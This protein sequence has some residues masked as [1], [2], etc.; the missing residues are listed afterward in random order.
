MQAQLAKKLLEVGGLLLDQEK[1]EVLI[2]PRAREEG[3]WFGGGNIAQAADGTFWLV[4]RYRNGGDS[5]VGIE[6]GPRGAELSLWKSEDGG[7]S[8]EEAFS[9]LKD[10]LAPEG[11]EVLSIEGASLCADESGV[12]L[13]VS[14]EK[15]RDY[16]A[17]VKEFQK[18]GTG[19]WSIDV[20]QAS[21]VE[22]L[23]DAEVKCVLRSEP[24]SWLHLKD[25]VVFDRDGVRTMLVCSHPYSWASTNTG[26]AL[27]DDETGEW[28]IK[29]WSIESRGPSWDVAV[30]R[31][32]ER[33][34]L[35]ESGSIDEKRCLYFYD[36]AEC[37][38]DHGG[39]RPKGYSCE[40]IGGLAAGPDGKFPDLTRLSVE[41]PA[42][43]SP[44]G[45]GCSRYC[46]VCDTGEQY[47]VTWQQSQPDFSQPL[48]VNRVEKA[49]VVGILEG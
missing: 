25:P 49:E 29:K 32:T 24:P 23:S 41:R 8:F 5:R 1:A 30:F 38:H 10:D 9:F 4:G 44:H 14:S 37:I 33:F 3:F 48:V 12:E 15:K 22:E 26:F 13:Y 20:I 17:R 2:E 6:A 40:E 42:F 43:V 19:V 45:T 18:S 36:G 21:E 7:E 47:L 35:P 16:P 11:E 27:R 46:S 34:V 28:K 31:V 39:D